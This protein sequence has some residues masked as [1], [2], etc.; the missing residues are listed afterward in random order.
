MHLQS[1]PLIAI[2]LEETYFY[3]EMFGAIL[4]AHLKAYSMT[5]RSTLTASR[6]MNWSFAL[7]EERNA[8]T[9]LE[10]AS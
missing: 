7:H 2:S 6:R 1:L 10:E 4:Y 3:M 9:S 8:I 5:N